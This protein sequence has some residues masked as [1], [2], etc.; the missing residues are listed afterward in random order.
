VRRAAGKPVLAARMGQGQRAPAILVGETYLE[1]TSGVTVRVL[2]SQHMAA[3]P[4]RF[5]VEAA[6]GS[7]PGEHWRCTADK[8]RGAASSARSPAP[9][10]AAARPDAIL[11]AFKEALSCTKRLL[12]S[13]QEA[14]N[15]GEV[16]RLASTLRLVA[17]GLAESGRG[18]TPIAR[19]G[20][21]TMMPGD[22][23]PTAARGSAI[24]DPV[25][26]LRDGPRDHRPAAGRR[27]L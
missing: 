24:G 21:I 6:D 7:R 19:A 4:V 9:T 16:G 8:L 14:V 27:G 11:E 13:G 2:D 25:R 18:E 20:V 22:A 23:Q 17:E 26:S 3:G 15:A 5:V 10:S 1:A 12:E